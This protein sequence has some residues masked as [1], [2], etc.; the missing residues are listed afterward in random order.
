MFADHDT[1]VTARRR[2]GLPVPFG[3]NK[4]LMPKLREVSVCAVYLDWTSATLTQFRNLRKLE[5]NQPFRYSP[6]MQKSL[7]LVVASPG[8]EIPGVSGYWPTFD[9]IQTEL[10]LLRL[11]ALKSF[12]FAWVRPG[13]ACY[14]LIV[15]QIPETL[16]ALSLADTEVGLGIRKMGGEDSERTA[17][18]LFTPRIFELF[19][20]LGSG[21]TRTLTPRNRGYPC[22]G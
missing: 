22:P 21:G 8:P 10:P 15:L 12:V 11:P 7:T 5:I 6:T 1:C 18:K 20:V 19:K 13:F 2:H 16:E 14:F 4:T 9:P 17:C 3:G